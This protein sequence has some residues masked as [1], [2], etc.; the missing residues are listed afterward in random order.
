M[1]N[2]DVNGGIASLN[3]VA[4]LP[5]EACQDGIS[6][7]FSVTPHGLGPDAEARTLNLASILDGYFMK[8]GQHININVLNR[9]QLIDAM[10]HP[11]RYPNLTV[12]VSGYAVNFNRLSRKHQQEI[13]DRT[14]H[15]RL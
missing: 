11:D 3:S 12:R 13:I 2:R 6:C 9:D 14:F 8:T 10:D 15:E 5:Y 7:T 4:K 1:H